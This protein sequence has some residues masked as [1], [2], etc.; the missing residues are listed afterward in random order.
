VKFIASMKLTEGWSEREKR[1]QREKNEKFQ[2]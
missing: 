2:G 1:T